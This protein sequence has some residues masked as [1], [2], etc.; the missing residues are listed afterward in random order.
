MNTIETV[1]TKVGLTKPQMMRLLE[2][3]PDNVALKPAQAVKIFTLA[4]D[5]IATRLERRVAGTP[6]SLV[7][8]AIDIGDMYDEWVELVL[9]RLR[10]AAD[11]SRVGLLRTRDGA[12]ILGI[13]DWHLSQ[14]RIRGQVEG[15][16]AGI[17]RFLYTFEAVE[18]LVKANS[19]ALGPDSTRY[20][21][22]ITNG[23]LAWVNESSREELAVPA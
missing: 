23:F 11:A 18:E 12:R 14:V 16:A 13:S 9:T 3:N 4:D 21:G 6:S 22:P 2:D 19:E 20:R 10:S 5:E 8:R 17:R 15:E 1:R 7:K